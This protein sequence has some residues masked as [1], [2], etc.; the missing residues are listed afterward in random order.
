MTAMQFA[1]FVMDYVSPI[2]LTIMFILMIYLF[3]TEA[4]I[5]RSRLKREREQQIH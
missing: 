2:G 5:S 1:N 4:L 3:V